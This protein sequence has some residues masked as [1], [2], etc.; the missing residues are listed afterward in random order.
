[1]K[2]C[3]FILKQD[4]KISRLTDKTFN[5]DNQIQNGFYSAKYFLK[6]QQILGQQSFSAIV[7]LQFF[8]RKEKATLCGIDEAIALI[9]KFAKNYNK[10]EIK[11][12]HDGDRISA[13]EPVLTIK[14]EYKDFGFLEGIID[15][16]LARRTSLATNASNLVNLLNPNQEIIFMGDR[17]DIYTT[18]SGDGYAVNIGGIKKVATDAMGAWTGVKGIGTMPHALIQNFNGNLVKACQ[19]YIDTFPDEP[20]IAL[21]DYNNDIVIDSLKVA[22]EF[23]Q[24]LT[25]IRVDT[26]PT[27]VDKY[28][29][30]NLDHMGSFDP[31]G[32]N[33][34][35]IKVLRRSLDKEGFH[36]VKIIAS[37]NFDYEKIK[38]F[39]GDSTPVDI[40]GVGSSLLKIKI[41]FTGDCVELNGKP[42]AK[43][44]R[45]KL[46]S[47]R[48]TLI[49]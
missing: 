12:L 7:L 45:K 10:L 30:R 23:G 26:S 37:G 48:L 22:H 9:K 25:A 1:M 34:E 3:E 39:Q 2:D 49:R 4:G 36:H 47:D 14:G 28:F 16:I 31:R 33:S 42:Q 44:G 29:L 13:F 40:Y 18:Q 17:E 11:A 21:V 35:L 6:T 38:Q 5:F 24:R 20:L 27:M 41:G 19:A 15:G 8:Q 32:V 46:D 43:L